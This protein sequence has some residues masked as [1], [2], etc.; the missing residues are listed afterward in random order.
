MI[1]IVDTKAEHF[2]IIVQRKIFEHSQAKRFHLNKFMLGD[3]SKTLM[4]KDEV[5][6]MVGAAQL[7]PGKFEVYAIFSE[8]IQAH[9]KAFNSAIKKLTKWFLAT[10]TP[11]RLQAY[12]RADFEIGQ[13]W[14]E[15][16]GFRAEGYL[17]KWGPT[18]LDYVIYGKVT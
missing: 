18:D 8:S 16:L 15:Y 3:N 12:V 4:L 7:F 5:I 10:Y 1:K 6:G 11:S 14:I 2:D 17:E 9:P 13:R